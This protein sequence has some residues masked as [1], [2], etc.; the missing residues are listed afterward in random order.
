MEKDEKIVN[1]LQL[2]Q[3]P[4]G[5]M[6]STSAIFKGFSAAILAGLAT[7]TI[8]DINIWALI[9]G[10]IPLIS[11]FAL[12]IFYLS[13]ERKLKYRY[14]QVIDGAIDLDY[15]INTKLNKVE[16]KEAKSSVVW[17]ILSPSI[18]LFYVPI[19]AC[20]IALIILKVKNVL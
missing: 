14:R 4:I 2:L 13:L 12:D 19:Y 20:G 6:S 16:K 5:R 18:W 8:T 17:C 11:F 3:E 10:L 7:A 1:Y 15:R 9:L